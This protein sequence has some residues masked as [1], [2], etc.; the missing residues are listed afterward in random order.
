MD[1]KVYTVESLKNLED[2]VVVIVEPISEKLP[3]NLMGQKLCI[4][5]VLEH[6]LLVFSSLCAG[7]GI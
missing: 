2:D 1:W 5:N 3:F 6:M 7:R 4:A